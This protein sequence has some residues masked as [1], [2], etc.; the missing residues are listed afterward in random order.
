MA[1]E[2]RSF[3]LITGANSTARVMV[4]EEDVGPALNLLEPEDGF[5]AEEEGAEELD[6]TSS[7]SAVNKT[8]LGATAIAFNPLGAGIAYAISKTISTEEEQT[9]G[10]Q[11]DCPECGVG[12]ELSD[13]ELVERRFTCP[14][15]DQVIGLDD[16]VICPSCRSE[17]ELDAVE[18]SRGWYIC[19]E[20]WRVVCTKRP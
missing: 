20:Y 18:Q 13:D 3:A 8:V 12:L 2:T 17:L 10:N 7:A 1:I 15:C 14:E 4:P 6:S 19:P 11:V 5:V 9:V 16:F